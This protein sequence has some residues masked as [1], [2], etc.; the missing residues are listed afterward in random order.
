MCYGKCYVFL[1]GETEQ[2]RGRG[3]REN[4]PVTIHPQALFI[5]PWKVGCVCVP[6]CVRACACGREKQEGGGVCS[7]AT[8]TQKSHYRAM[9]L[10]AHM[11]RYPVLVI[12]QFFSA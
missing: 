3:I 8:C 6:M 5:A 1:G 11:A 2:E 12:V 10:G 9:H 7:V 4:Q